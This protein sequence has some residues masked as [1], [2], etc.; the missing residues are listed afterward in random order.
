[1]ASRRSAFR[2]D[3][4]RLPVTYKTAYTEGTANLINISTNGCALESLTVPLSEQQNFLVSITLEGEGESIE[5]RAIAVRRTENGIAAKF[6]IIEENSRAAL[7]KY[8]SKRIRNR[9]GVTG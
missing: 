6:L 8:F 3:G 9:S 5:A 4:F 7:R 2:F 1:M